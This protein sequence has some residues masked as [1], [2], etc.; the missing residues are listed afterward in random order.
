LANTLLV[1]AGLDPAAMPRTLVHPQ[2][3]RVYRALVHAD[4]G[5]TGVDGFDKAEVTSGGVRLGELDRR[6]LESRRWPGLFVCGEVVNC[7][8]RLGGFNFQWAWSSGFAAGRGA[9]G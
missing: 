7:T 1:T 5:L 6:T 3:Q 8:G 4:A 9:A 2:W